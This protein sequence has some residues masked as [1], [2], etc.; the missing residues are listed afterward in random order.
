VPQFASSAKAIASHHALANSNPPRL[1]NSSEREGES[2]FAQMLDSANP[3]QDQ[4]QPQPK[5]RDAAPRNDQPD[6]APQSAKPDDAKAD[7][8]DKTCSK[9]AK[10]A[11]DKTANAD[12][13][14]A[15]DS[16]DPTAQTKDA[17]DKGDAKAADS[18]AAALDGQTADPTKQTAQAA[19]PDASATAS[20]NT[21]QAAQLAANAT[22]AAIPTLADATATVSLDSLKAEINAN[23]GPKAKLAAP[24]MA[25]Q[26]VKQDDAKAIDA[27]DRKLAPEQPG[28]P[29]QAASADDLKKLAAATT[30]RHDDDDAAPVHKPGHE[31]LSQALDPKGAGA[32]KASGDPVQITLP[33]QAAN[34]VPQNNAAQ[35]S[36]I[37]QSQ[38]A[39]AVP[40]QGLGVELAGKALAGKNHFE[41]RLDPPELGRIEVRLD[42][43]KQGQ[44]TSRLIADRADTLDLL[45]RDA[46]TLERA[47]Q[48]AGLKTDSNSLQFSLRDQPMYRENNQDQSKN[49]TQ[50][51]IPDDT[52]PAI[53]A[54]QRSYSR[55]A[56][57][58]GGVDIRV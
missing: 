37:Q 24:L 7:K 51:V 48:D 25:T 31:D 42:V 15:S 34:S 29:K 40:I 20:T 13:A 5:S 36:I 35:P 46:P 4:Q 58:G 27:D 39:A 53:E 57:L 3:A 50:L 10:S 14:N 44:V 55:L 47:L 32:T 16:A 23:A 56:G 45:R 2:P 8:A 19:T 49:S 12:A 43:D 38:Q 41:I 17:K 1:T 30:A 52:L 54:T 33:A 28:D 18:L 11:D 21:A 26:L 22:A 9:D 6:N